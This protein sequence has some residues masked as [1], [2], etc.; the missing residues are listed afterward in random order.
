MTDKVKFLHTDCDPSLAEDKSLPNTSYL[1]EYTLD[2]M[3]KFD[4][5]VSSKKVYIFD[6][7]WDNYR[8]D[9][10]NMTQTAGIINPRLWSET[11]KKKKSK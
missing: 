7:Y 3:T 11:T 9:F 6:H 10:I 8:G 4:I 1:I 5:V 2:G